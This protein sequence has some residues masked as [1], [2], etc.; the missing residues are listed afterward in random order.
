MS[1]RE[2]KIK[3]GW[4][5]DNSYASLPEIFYRKIYPVP[6]RSPYMIVLNNTL[7]KTL[8]LNIEDLNSQ[9][10]IYTLAGNS[11]PEGSIPIA[12]AY[13]GHQFAHFTMLGDGRAVLLGE[14][15]T[16]DN[17][18]LDIQLKGSGRTPFSRGGD[19][20]ASLG[21]MLREY[22]MSEAMNSLKIATTRSLAVVETG[23]PVY[24]ETVLKGA[25]LTRVASSHI[26]VGTF[27]YAANWGSKDDLRALA[28]YTINRHFSYINKDKEKYLLLLEEIIKKQASLIS[29]W[30][31]AGFIHGVMNTD[32]MAVSGETIDYGPCAFMDAYNPDTVFSSIDTAGR[33]AYKN[34]PKIGEWNLLRLAEA[35]ISILHDDEGTAVK[36]AQDAV[37]QFDVLFINNYYEGMRAK[38]G[39]FNEEKEDVSL[40]NSLLDLM[41]RYEA[42]YTYTFNALTENKLEDTILHGNSEFMNWYNMWQARLLKQQSTK[43]ETKQLMRSSNPSIIPRNYLVENAL[44]E[45]IHNENY[46]V[47]NNLLSA[48]SN[49]YSDNKEYE[50]YKK[51]PPPTTCPYRTFCGT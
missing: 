39:L 14:Q 24:R 51:L 48:V 2:L 26:R 49:P 4:N 6:V 17:E 16:P 46:S 9:D 3:T 32:N 40:I 8:G 1:D 19:G 28:D 37:S 43:E 22:I 5:L 36:M 38:I 21:P 33:Y 15:I 18:R 31:L 10:G 47:M 35:M 13:S 23:E 30:Q 7:A 29:K 25:V 11:I 45:A 12:Q 42:D 34:Q 20:R 44:N 50:E 27:Q 41:R